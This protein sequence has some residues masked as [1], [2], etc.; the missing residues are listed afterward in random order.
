MKSSTRTRSARP[1]AAEVL[2]LA[3]PVLALT[4]NYFI[5]PDLSYQGLATQEAVF[6]ASV[7]VLTFAGL[8]MLMRE[9]AA[10]VRIENR[11]LKPLLA[12]FAFLVWQMISLA[13]APAPYDG[14]RIAGVWLGFGALFA[15]GALQLG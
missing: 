11:I 8:I 15:F 1:G 6:G 9:P 14:V 2:Y 12:L 5:I 13:W 10:S 4:P 7:A 3:A